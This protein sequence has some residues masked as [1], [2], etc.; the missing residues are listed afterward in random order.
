MGNIFMNTKQREM[1]LGTLAVILLLVVPAANWL[2][3]GFSGAWLP[4]SWTVHCGGG[5]RGGAIVMILLILEH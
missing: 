1:V 5:E 2:Y 3:Y 4:L